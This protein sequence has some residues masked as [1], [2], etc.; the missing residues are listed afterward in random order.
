[1]PKKSFSN[2]HRKSRLQQE[3]PKHVDIS[4]VDEETYQ[5]ISAFPD[6]IST[7]ITFR[8]SILRYLASRC[9]KIIPKTIE[10]HRVALQ[11]LHDRNIP[12]AISIYRWWLVFRASEFNPVSLAPRNKDKGNSKV[13]VPAFVDALMKQAVERVISG[14]K[15]RI[16]SAYKRVR[17]KLRQH[18]LNNGTKYKYPT[19]ESLRKRVKKKTPFEILARRRASE[20]RKESSVGWGKRY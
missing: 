6:N 4:D 19:Y 2:F 11:R 8:L 15:V 20:L 18:N 17:R 14:R 16:R 7:Q 13:K 3:E 1:M 10:P 12:S 5:D 9:E